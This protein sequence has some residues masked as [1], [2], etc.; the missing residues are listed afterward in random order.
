M[1]RPPGVTG[2][3]R[4]RVLAVLTALA[5][6]VP[7]GIVDLWGG[8]SA[9]AAPDPAD[10]DPGYIISDSQFYDADAMTADEIKNFLNAKIGTCQNGQCLNVAKVPLESR[11][12]RYAADAPY[13]LVCE[14]I[15]GGDLWVWEVIYR[16]QVACGISAK[17]ILVT[18]QKE[19]GLVTKTA[20]SDYALKYAMGYGCPDTA[21]CSSA[22]AGLGY[23]LYQGARQLKTYKL[24]T[25]WNFQP[26]PEYV[27]FHPSGT[28]GG[29][30]VDIR[31]FATAALYNYTPY[32]PNAAALGN[33]YGTGDSCS[34]YGNRNF[35]R[36]YSD[37]FGNPTDLKPE[38]VTVSRVGGATR[39]DVAVGVSTASFAAGVPVVYIAS[40]ENFPDAV[41]AGPAAAANDGPVLLVERTSIPA[42]V[43]TE[44]RRLAPA[45]IIVVGGPATVSAA[46]LSQLGGF[47][48]VVT[49]VSGADRYEVS[50]DLALDSFPTGAGVAYLATGAVFAD[51]LSSG[52]AAG[53]A[54]GP[55]ILVDGKLGAVDA[56]TWDVLT[57]LGVTQVRIA[58]GPGSVS[59]GILQD[60]QG[61]LGAANVMRLGGADRFAVS[62]AVNMDVFTTTDTFYV[63]SGFSFP[64]ALSATPAAVAAGAPLYVTDGTCLDRAMI[65]HMIDAGATKL[66][67]V[68]GPASVTGEAAAFRN[69]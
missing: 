53:S 48:P 59:T 56:A 18:L 22:V 60:L 34:S 32:Q 50:R 64:D 46:V 3:P 67:I 31:N 8:A 11:P 39:Y 13:S 19:Q 47:A 2:R 45:R 24:W 26:G 17:V 36:Y 41:S 1:T 25:G 62:A 5:L 69:C 29:T 54:G 14:A 27:S 6:L 51:A 20:P 57:T 33:L 7:V 10:F 40:G 9:G 23:Q 42:A 55:V 58:G 44:L 68:G 52:A 38:N 61:R 49:R 16:V 65:Q 4:S 28:C 21:G 66:V 35:W 15:T 12:A 37:W 43:A 30:T 63:A